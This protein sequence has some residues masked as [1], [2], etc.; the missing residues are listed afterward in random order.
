MW[1]PVRDHTD[2]AQHLFQKEH[3]DRKKDGH[4]RQ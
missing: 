1:S 4:V 3:R 2:A